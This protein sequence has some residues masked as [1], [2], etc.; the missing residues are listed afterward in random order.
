V[1]EDP[2]DNTTRPAPYGAEPTV[3]L[4][5]VPSAGQHGSQAGQFGGLPP[6]FG[7]T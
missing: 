2:P 3:D 1:A 4:A 7:V 5:P 6:I